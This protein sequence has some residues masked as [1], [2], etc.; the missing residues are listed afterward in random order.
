MVGY[1]KRNVLFILLLII[2]TNSI[3]A[4]SSRLWAVRPMLQNLSKRFSSNVSNV[5]RATSLLSTNPSIFSSRSFSKGTNNSFSTNQSLLKLNIPKVIAATL[6][7]FETK[8]LLTSYYREKEIT[9]ALEQVKNEPW[10][11]DSK[12]DDITQKFQHTE[13]G[14]KAQVQLISIQE[15]AMPL[16]LIFKNNGPE[17]FLNAIVKNYSDYPGD[18]FRRSPEYMRMFTKFTPEEKQQLLSTIDEQISNKE[19]EL[20][21]L[22]TEP[23]WIWGTRQ[24][25]AFSLDEKNIIFTIKK[26]LEILNET[27]NNLEQS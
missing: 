1:M 2:G 26:E 6:V 19:K 10:E 16:Y 17:S 9:S 21:L 25:T 11:K 8:H 27:K 15:K 7:L 14:K 5:P 22:T 4:G 13:R 23:G 3:D 24:K 18:A 12:F 20:E